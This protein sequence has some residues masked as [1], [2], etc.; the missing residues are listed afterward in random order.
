MERG[1]YVKMLIT[2]VSCVTVRGQAE[3]VL[4][5]RVPLS[6]LI[7]DSLGLHPSI[8]ASFHSSCLASPHWKIEGCVNH[9]ITWPRAS[10][11]T[12][13]EK[14]QR[15]KKNKKRTG[16]ETPGFPRRVTQPKLGQVFV[17]HPLIYRFQALPNK[18]A[19][20]KSVQSVSFD[21]PSHF[22][23]LG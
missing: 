2:V 13:K 22:S 23:G 15:I 1:K 10:K 18:K 20:N 4:A 19:K 17:I 11:P 16:N 14:A 3:T 5:Q 12:H 8:F 9:H 7:S 6:T 21:H